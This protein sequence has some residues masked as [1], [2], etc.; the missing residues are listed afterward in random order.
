MVNGIVADL[1]QSRSVALGFEC[2]LFIPITENPMLLTCARDGEAPKGG[3]S[4][5]WSASSGS[6]ALAIG[7]AE[8]V[9]IL[10]QVQRAITVA[11]VPTLKWGRFAKGKANLFLWE[12]FVS[13]DAKSKNKDDAVAHIEDAKTAA[14]AFQK[15]LPDFSGA[16]D[17]RADNPYSLIGAAMLRAGLT[18]DLQVL[19]EPCVVIKA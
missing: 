12:A 2:P 11:V 8:S 6:Y 7:L 18:T 19:R 13:G 4:R 16:S 14:L 5:P 1:E 15:R 9:W 10:E 17:V 3:E